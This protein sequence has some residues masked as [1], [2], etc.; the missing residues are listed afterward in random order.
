MVTFPAYPRRA[1]QA[2]LLAM[3]VQI[4]HGRS[5]IVTAGRW[6]ARQRQV[7]RQRRITTADRRIGNGRA[8]QCN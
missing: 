5:R 4:W 2:F 7:H 6:P 3:A 8:R 1:Q